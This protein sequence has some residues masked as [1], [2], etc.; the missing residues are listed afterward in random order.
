MA[1]AQHVQ[2]LCTGWVWA[3]ARGGGRTCRSA[4]QSSFSGIPRSCWIDERMFLQT[5]ST[6]TDA[7]V[8]DGSEK[9]QQR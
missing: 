9:V 1:V 4:I 3:D 7:A 8:S 5:T 6:S 2:P